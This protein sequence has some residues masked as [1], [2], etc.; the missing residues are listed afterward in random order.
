VLLAAAIGATSL[1]GSLGATST[2][3]ADGLGFNTA[4]K[5]PT[6]VQCGGYEPGLV[7]DSFGNVVVTAHKQNHCD[8]AGPDPAGTI[9]ARAQSWLWTSSDDVN[10][11]DMPGLTA[12]GADRLDFG[13][14]GDVARD[15]SGNLYFVDTKVADNTFTSWKATGLGAITETAQTPAMGTAQPVDDRPWITAHGNGLVVYFGNEG[16]KKS[17]PAGQVAPGS[18]PGRYTAYVSSNGG[19]TFDPVGYQLP[20]SGWCRPGADHT[21]GSHLLYMVCTN[22]GGADDATTFAC[23]PGFKTGELYSYVS[24]DDGKTWTRHDIRPYNAC[25]PV[26]SWPA[27]SVAANGDVYAL[28]LDSPDASG[29]A[30][31]TGPLPG[32]GDPLASITATA[33]QL[34]LFRST[35]HGQTWAERDVTPDPTGNYHYAWMDVAPDGTIGVVYYHAVD[36][37]S[38]WYVEAETAP[39]FTAPFTT[40]RVWNQRV[41]TAAFGPFGDF[42]ECAFG[43]DNRLR[44]VWTSLS[45][46]VGQ[47]FTYGL[48]SDI[49]YAVQS[50]AAPPASV[51]EAPLAA[52]LLGAGAVAGVAAVLV[53]RR[54]GGAP[55]G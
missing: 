25:N 28:Y 26:D 12:L 20:D 13:D 29:S 16:D 42:F 19:T 33:Q 53:R 3:R 49:Y 14:E 5:L 51:P 52:S 31:P 45:T 43:P 7:V 2:A 30:G 50:P 44:V 47:D 24:A 55:T 9:P 15:D 54:R 8:A 10:F 11:T 41:S 4:V 6:Y 34:R 21:P 18:G 38:D 17:Y 1:L 27:V 37:N 23:S 48:N 46:L 22:D 35:D 36:G 40:G 32:A 39:D